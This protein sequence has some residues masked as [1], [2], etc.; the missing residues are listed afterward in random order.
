M[1]KAAQEKAL[2]QPWFDAVQ[3]HN[4]DAKEALHILREIPE[5]NAKILFN[6][7]HVASALKDFTV[8]EKSLT[9]SIA[10]DKYSAVAYFCRAT[11]RFNLKRYKDALS[12]FEVSN[13]QLRDNLMIDYKQLNFKYET[14]C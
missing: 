3:V 13:E 7:G 9:D 8:A 10:K 1:S 6:I 14:P 2:L 5:P 4:D 11:V 12:D